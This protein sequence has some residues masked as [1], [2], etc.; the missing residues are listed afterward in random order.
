MLFPLIKKLLSRHTSMASKQTQ[1]VE[2]I[3]S[4]E[5]IK[6]EAGARSAIPILRKHL[7]RFPDD[8]LALNNLGCCL[9]DIGDTAGASRLFE[10]AF[11]LDDSYQP[12]V[13]NHAKHL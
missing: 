1:Q 12:V 6:L 2:A 5:A 11:S 3:E 8:I 9:A 7:E 10:L 4:S 13:I